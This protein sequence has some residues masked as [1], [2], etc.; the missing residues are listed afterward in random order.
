MARLPLFPPTRASWRDTTRLLSR[1]SASRWAVP[2]HSTDE[3][4]VRIAGATTI[5]NGANGL[6][7]N[8]PTS[9]AVSHAPHNLERSASQWPGLCPS[10]L[11]L[12]LRLFLPISLT[13]RTPV[14]LLL[15]VIHFHSIRRRCP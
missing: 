13:S 1:T 5:V 15:A 3:A 4:F 11:R 2:R 10:M 7:V 6:S 9:I 12:R 8:D 14:G